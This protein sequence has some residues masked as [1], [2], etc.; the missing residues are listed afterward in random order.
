MTVTIPSFGKSNIDCLY[1]NLLL[2]KGIESNVRQVLDL[3][4]FNLYRYDLEIFYAIDCKWIVVQSGE[5]E[6]KS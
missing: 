1:V 5:L 6:M 2:H 3:L 4:D